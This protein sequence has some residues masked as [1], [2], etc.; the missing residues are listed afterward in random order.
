MSNGHDSPTA[1]HP[2][3]PNELGGYRVLRRP[4]RGGA[5]TAYLAQAPS[6]PGPRPPGSGRFPA[7]NNREQPERVG[8]S[9]SVRC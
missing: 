3:D 6:G 4:G 5:G 1:Q 2:G 8:V 7:R 9:A